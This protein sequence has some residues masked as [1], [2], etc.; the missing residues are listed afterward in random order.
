MGAWRR[1][2]IQALLTKN[3]QSYAL[4]VTLPLPMLLTMAAPRKA[5]RVQRLEI[6]LDQPL[7]AWLRLEAKRLDC[8]MSEVL[9]R[10]VR[11][12]MARDGEDGNG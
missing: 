6:H 2:G 7:L 9:R 12:E 10:L 8:S 5:Q 4:T 1:E 11:K 3:R